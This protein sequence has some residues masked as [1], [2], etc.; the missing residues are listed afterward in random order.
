MTRKDYRRPSFHVG[1]WLALLVICV[2]IL[3]ASLL[4]AR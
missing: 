3:I 2:L 1:I 4:A